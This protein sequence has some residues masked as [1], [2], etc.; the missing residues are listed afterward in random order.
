MSVADTVNVV[1]I[2]AEKNS[3]DG[4]YLRFDY[5]TNYVHGRILYSNYPLTD[6]QVLQQLGI[7]QFSQHAAATEAENA[8][9]NE[10]ND[11]NSDQLV[12]YFLTFNNTLF[13]VE[14]IA[15]NG[16]VHSLSVLPGN[17]FES[18]IISV[19]MSVGTVTRY[20]DEYN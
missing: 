15:D 13:Q 3:G 11:E 18:D 9:E 6:L 5:H 17:E 4:L 19:E 2:R 16:R 10:G 1:D 8:E 14:N 12:G 20:I 7:P